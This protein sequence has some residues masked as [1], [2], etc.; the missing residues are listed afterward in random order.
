MLL[1]DIRD[2]LGHQKCSQLCVAC[3]NEVHLLEPASNVF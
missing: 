1:V 3:E 2:C